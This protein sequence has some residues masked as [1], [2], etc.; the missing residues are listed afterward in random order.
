MH[1]HRLLYLL[2]R[3]TVKYIK[4]KLTDEFESCRETC[5]TVDCGDLFWDEKHDNAARE[6]IMRHSAL[7]TRSNEK[8]FHCRRSESFCQELLSATPNL[9]PTFHRTR[10]LPILPPLTKIQLRTQI[11]DNVCWATADSMEPHVRRYQSSQ[12]H[13][14]VLP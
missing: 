11:R 6:M 9:R 1:M 4:Q 14:N 13:M 5:T 2:P 7:G 12:R 3:D 10:Q 8:Y